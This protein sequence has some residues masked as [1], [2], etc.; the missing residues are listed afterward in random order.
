MDWAEKLYC[1]H[2]L[3][4]RKRDGDGNDCG[5][6][7]SPPAPSHAALISLLRVVKAVLI[8]ALTLT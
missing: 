8:L 5:C 2:G 1:E 7:L 4:H 3:P 6:L